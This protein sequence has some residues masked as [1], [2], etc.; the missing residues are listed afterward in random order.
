MLAESLQNSQ[1]G[2][3]I[4]LLDTLLLKTGCCFDSRPSYVVQAI[5]N[6]HYANE[7]KLMESDSDVVLY[8]VL[9][10]GNR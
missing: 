2:V 8:A 9:S 6:A 7:H 5:Q 10:V 1:K 4:S 3:C